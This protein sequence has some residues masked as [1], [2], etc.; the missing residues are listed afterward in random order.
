[1]TTINV[2]VKIQLE[3]DIEI[4][5]DDLIHQSIDDYMEYVRSHIQ[6][7]VDIDSSFDWEMP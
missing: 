2:K 1:M 6:D 3:E 7:Y 5:A 4:E